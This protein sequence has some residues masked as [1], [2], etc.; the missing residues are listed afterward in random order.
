MDKSTVKQSFPDFF[1]DAPAVTMR[2]PLA[3][4]LGTARGGV[5]EYRYADAVRLAGHSCPTV[6]GAWLMTIHGLRALYG[7]E[8]PVR[9]EI[10]VFM[11][12]AR[13]AGTTGVVATVAQLVTGAAPETGFHGIGGRFGRNDLLHFDQSMQ[14]EFGLR[15]KD[16]GAA[17]Q[18]VLDASVVPWSNEMRLLLPKA[19]SRQAS[20]DE[21]QRFGELW[22]ER[23]RQIL[24]EHAN[25]THLVQVSTWARN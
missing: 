3:Q 16:T 20:P 10:E 13:D 11:A 24:V 9:G 8:L 19:V 4:F 5:M 21:L 15:R 25:D 1:A 14:G 6:A 23:V 12:D 7:D 17:V 2:D 22:Q 18:V